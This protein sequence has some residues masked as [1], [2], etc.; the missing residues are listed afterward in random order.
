MVRL[1][2][3]R[4]YRKIVI[5]GRVEALKYAAN[6]KRIHDLLFITVKPKPPGYGDKAK[7]GTSL[8]EEWSNLNACLSYLGCQPFSDKVKAIRVDFQDNK[9]VLK[10]LSDVGLLGE[11]KSHKLVIFDAD[12]IN[13]LIKKEQASFNGA[14]DSYLVR[15][16]ILIY[17]MYPLQGL[18][19][20][21]VRIEDEF[22]CGG[23]YF[24]Y[25]NKLGNTH[26]YTPD[27]GERYNSPRRLVEITSPLMSEA[28]FLEYD[29]GSVRMALRN[30]LAAAAF[31]GRT[32]EPIER[33][34]Y[35]IR[36][37]LYPTR[38]YFDSRAIMYDPNMSKK[39]IQKPVQDVRNLCL[40]KSNLIV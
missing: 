37:F 5:G 25:K 7:D 21:L 35:T 22:F 18:P 15:D 4:T 12:G 40:P 29:V 17:K 39:T 30:R 38:S 9:F 2:F 36:K 26:P 31:D 20:K 33:Q 16:T 1:D 10:V 14:G 34:V 3:T 13:M 11:V 23:A 27:Q 28:E 8:L 19:V 6:E 32:F 24:Y